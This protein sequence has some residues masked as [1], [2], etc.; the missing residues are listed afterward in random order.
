MLTIKNLE[1]TKELSRDERAAVRGG[2]GDQANATTQGNGQ[3]MLAP[4][5]VA[6]GALFGAGS[7]S[8]Q[9]HSNPTQTATNDSDSYN[10]KGLGLY[11][12]FFN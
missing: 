6:N 3:Q 7:A 8:I 10:F 5:H 9:V 1:I 11:Y 2:I 12:P 4:V